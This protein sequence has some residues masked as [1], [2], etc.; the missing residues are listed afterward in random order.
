MNFLKPILIILFFV[1][2]TN[3]F[4]QTTLNSKILSL[5]SKEIG[6]NY[7]YLASKEYILNNNRLTIIGQENNIDLSLDKRRSFSYKNNRKTFEEVIKLTP[8]TP[9]LSKYKADTILLYFNNQELNKVSW[10]FRLKKIDIPKIEA[11]LETKLGNSG[12]SS[13]A[14]WG[15]KVWNDKYSELNIFHGNNDT[16]G[17]FSLEFEMYE[18]PISKE[19]ELRIGKGNSTYIPDITFTKNFLLSNGTISSFEKLLPDFSVQDSAF[20]SFEYNPLTQQH[21]IFSAIGFYYYFT[22]SDQFDVKAIVTANKSN[23]VTKIE[24]FFTSEPLFK[25]NLTK[26]KTQNGFIVNETMTKAERKLGGNNCTVYSNKQKINLT[27]FTGK[28]FSLERY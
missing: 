21:D 10:N 22:F 9:F 13:N 1:S 18:K 3:I 7:I 23:I 16:S 15:G 5:L 28:Q 14:G 11:D 19:D 4:S 6:I 12:Y 27:I 26:Q 20:K 25:L 24:Y 17:F 8:V 2:S